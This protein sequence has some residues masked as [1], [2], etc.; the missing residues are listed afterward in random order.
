MSGLHIFTF[1][2]FI[3]IYLVARQD[4]LL[5]IFSTF[6]L[7]GLLGYVF[8]LIRKLSIYMYFDLHKKTLIDWSIFISLV[9]GYF[10]IYVLSF[11]LFFRILKLFLNTL[12]LLVS[13]FFMIIGIILYIFY[14]KQKRWNK[15]YEILK[16]TL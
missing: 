14:H 3:L 12:L 11:I 4:V 9:L 6:L 1:N 7:V 13:S 8:L 16:S 2:L 10:I 15:I 5:M